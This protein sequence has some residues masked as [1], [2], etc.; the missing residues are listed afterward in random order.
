MLATGAKATACSSSILVPL[1]SL[2]GCGGEAGV[3][4]S[5]FL[6]GHRIPAPVVYRFECTPRMYSCGVG[7]GNRPPSAWGRVE[8]VSVSIVVVLAIVLRSL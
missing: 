5:S 4:A 3:L 1:E 2:W 7:L 8:E 6:L